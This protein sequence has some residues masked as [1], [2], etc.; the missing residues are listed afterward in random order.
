[1]GIPASPGGE[2]GIRIDLSFKFP[3]VHPGDPH[4]C[5]DCHGAGEVQ[6]IRVRM[7]GPD[8]FDNT[9]GRKPCDRCKGLGLDPEPPPDLAE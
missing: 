7:V 8:E 6:V 3:D 9:P 4:A 5:P 2:P 1:M